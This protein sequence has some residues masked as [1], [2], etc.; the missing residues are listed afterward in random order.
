MTIRFETRIPADQLE[1]DKSGHEDVT[2]TLELSHAQR[3]RS[4]LAAL[5]PDGQG[6]AIILAAREMMSPGDVL[7]SECGRHRVLIQ[8]AP[9]RL[10]QITAQDPFCLMRI[11]YHLANR[12]VRAMLSAQAVFIEPD[13]VLADMVKRLGGAVSEV[14]QGFVPEAGA[15]AAGH[16]HHHH[17]AEQA[18]DARMGSVGEALSRQAHA[19]RVGAP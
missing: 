8:A 5:L 15:Y 19:A 2:Q 11:V 6:A 7:V 1:A 10:L 17:E 9:E 18:D 12:H 3:S 16:H 4:R 14:E 13:A